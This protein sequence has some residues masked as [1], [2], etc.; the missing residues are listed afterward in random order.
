MDYW[1]QEEPLINDDQQNKRPKRLKR[2]L[3]C[4]VGLAIIGMAGYGMSR[5]I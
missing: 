4:V 3:L 2:V 5:F 1:N